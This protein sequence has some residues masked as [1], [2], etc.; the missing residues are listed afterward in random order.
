MKY[1]RTDHAITDL[2]S[3]AESGDREAWSTLFDHVYAELR[4]IARR[5]LRR[6]QGGTLDTTELVHDAYLKLF[7]TG[8]RSAQ[9]RAH[10]FALA[11]RAMR[12]VLVDHFRHRRAKKRGGTVVT[13]D[14]GSVKGKDTGHEG[15][16]LAVDQALNRLSE[17]DPRLGR[18]VECK[19]FGGMTQCEIGQALGIS[20]R[21][22]RSD[23][24]SAKA[25]LARELG[26]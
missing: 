23:W 13:L 20:E 5:Q 9:N 22:V 15:T 14:L 18:V 21:T 26:A 12:Q 24:R 17:M 1:A 3:R 10:F 19:F 16:V 7:G 2:L 8:S 25:W 6:Q 4:R 11:A